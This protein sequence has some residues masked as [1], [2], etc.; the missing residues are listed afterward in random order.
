MDEQQEY[1]MLSQADAAR[2]QGDLPTAYKLLARVVEESPSNFEARRGLAVLMS[3][4]GSYDDAIGHMRTV[5]D[6]YPGV[7]RWHFDLGQMLEA[8]GRLEEAMGSFARAEELDPS[9]SL[10]PGRI[11]MLS[12]R[13]R[14]GAGCREAAERALRLN[15]H[16]HRA[17]IA[18]AKEAM[19][20]GDLEEAEGR[21]RTVVEH[22]EEPI[23]QATG[24]HEVGR[25]LEER[26]EHDEAFD[27]HM[28]AN[29]LKLG[30]SFSREAMRSK[31]LMHFPG[32]LGHGDAPAR[33]KAWGAKRYDDGI[34]APVV[35]AG[36]PRSG[37][38]L[39]EQILAA[40]PGLAT[41]EEHTLCA[42]VR[43]EMDTMFGKKAMVRPILE[44]LD[45]LSDDQVR[46]LRR[47]Y[48]DGLVRHV[49]EGLRERT[50]VDKHPFRTLDLGLM[51][52]I[53]PE[54]RV[55][56]MIRDPRDVCLSSLFQDFNVNP[57]VVRLFSLPLCADWYAKVMGFW[58]KVRPLLSLEV[59]EVRYEDLVTDFETWARR[60]VE[61]AG[62]EWDERVLRF[63]AEAGERVVRSTSYE[64][65]TEGV[66]T[67]AIGRWKRYAQKLEPIMERLAPFVEAFGYE[68]GGPG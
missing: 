9:E 11:A 50:L 28:S 31:V 53:F 68:A 32:Y 51:N 38:T 10:Y 54:A 58:L 57:G 13:L 49:P 59:L 41:C 15:P 35:L 46:R 56:T 19:R 4:F 1:M 6:S 24:W 30:M 65:V 48:R 64:A 47:L 43:A 22:A 12:R 5:L 7:A 34:P 61:F 29:R 45:G 25:V 52:R 40:H 14:D 62:V 44:L 18:L 16:E 36:F 17:L 2:Q 27:A 42:P 8:S 63:H 66:H 39:A 23:I 60:M 67:R 3:M 37:T 55:I 21:A 33:Y 20:Q 26:G